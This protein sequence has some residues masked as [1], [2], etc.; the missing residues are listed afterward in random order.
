[1]IKKIKAFVFLFLV[2]LSAF[3][4]ETD[5]DSVLQSFERYRDAILTDKGSIAADYVDSR[6]MKYYSDILEKVK[7]A[8]SVEINSMGIIDKLTLLSIR[9]KAAKEELISFNGR[10]LFEYAI[11]EGMV[12][13]NSVMNTSLGDVFT[14]GDFAKAELVVNDQ[15][16]S[17]YFH[18]Y[19]EENIWKLD[20]THLFS[21]GAMS[22][23]KM[24]EDS[25]ETE[26]VFI[27]NILEVLTGKKPS[28]DIWKPLI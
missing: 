1:M 9:H 13:K 24:I 18:F 3:A 20:I 2:S 6:T 8:D 11:K 14:Q 25:G 5:R 7:F 15:K 27:L 12:G 17:F 26:N 23:N 16:T 28:K 19:R 10:A 21:V 22:L 4:Q